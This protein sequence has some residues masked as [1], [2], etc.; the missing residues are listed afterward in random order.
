MIENNKTNY[1]IG[2]TYKINGFEFTGDYIADTNSF[3]NFCTANIK[4]Q[5]LGKD[6]PIWDERRPHDMY[7]ITIL[8]TRNRMSFKFYDSIFDTE[9]NDKRTRFNQK[10]G[11]TLQ[12]MTL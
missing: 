1:K 6:Y 4:M 2:E 11:F 3:L 12:V 8:T 9:K 10:R 5:Y 7:Y